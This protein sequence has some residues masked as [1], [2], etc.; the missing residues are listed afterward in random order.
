MTGATVL[1]RTCAVA[2]AAAAVAAAAAAAAANASFIVVHVDA[3]A[4]VVIHPLMFT[5]VADAVR[6]AGSAADA[7]GAAVRDVTG[8]R[9]WPRAE[10]GSRKRVLTMGGASSATGY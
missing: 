2:A 8:C 6:A 5:T 7:A 4:E 3:G 10:L 9:G 1:D